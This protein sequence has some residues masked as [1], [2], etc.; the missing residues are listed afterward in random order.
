MTDTKKTR[1]KAAAAA[2]PPGGDKSG[3]GVQKAGGVRHA[4]KGSSSGCGRQKTDK[5][6]SG[7][8]SGDKAPNGGRRFR[9]PV[10][11][12][13]LALLLLK[14]GA[15]AWMLAV[16]PEMAE[17]NPRPPASLV[18]GGAAEE[19]AARLPLNQIVRVPAKSVAATVD[20]YLAAAM[21]VVAAPRVAQA[22]APIS[23]TSLSIAPIASGA[24]SVVFG[25]SA[26]APMAQG[27]EV[28][29]IPLPP[30]VDLLSPAAELPPPVLPTLGPG[31]TN[32]R[33][34]GSGGAAPLPP[35]AAAPVLPGISQ[36]VLRQREQA[37][38]VKEAELASREEALKSLDA[39]IR[40]R[41]S[42]I[43]NFRNEHESMISRNEAVLAEMKALREE[44][45]KE[46]EMRKDGSLQ[47]LVAAYGAMKPEQAGALV[48]SL[49]DDV[50]VS[51]LSV[52]PGRKA[53][54]ILA[55]VI[56]EK[57]ARLT[58][59]ISER[60]IDPSLILSDNPA[61]AGAPA[62]P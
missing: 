56:P 43:E 10:I 14:I 32:N 8:P 19:D 2:P 1:R 12:V 4:G 25:Q 38:A 57:A 46:D 40:Q 51:I 58:K 24:M 11:E 47:Q 42:D 17:L 26:A 61:G 60:R 37:L 22:S 23:A 35:N 33:P 6:K 29:P 44:Q 7:A 21:E 27:G 54:M 16:G 52:M 5:I 20:A 39:D 18:S 36:E 55:N 49:D 31:V 62:L 15:G 30:G 3:R 34:Q 41:M 53:G 28:E 9:W 50:A 13:V 59:A 45:K 48:N